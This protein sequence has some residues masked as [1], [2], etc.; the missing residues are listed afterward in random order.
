MEQKTK[1]LIIGAGP[2]GLM[3]AC[4]LKVQGVEPIII[5]ETDG[6]TKESR[7]VVVHARSIEIYD[8]LGIANE[9][10]LQGA[11]V[12]K[13]QLVIAN[14]KVQQLPFG[15]IGEGLSPFPFI[16]VL[17]QSKNEA[18][19]YEKLQKEGGSVSW[20]TQL[21]SIQEEEG[22]VRAVVRR[23]EDTFDIVADYVIAADGGKSPTRYALDVPFNGDTYEQIFFVADTKVESQ[24]GKDELTI[25]LSTE[26]FLA[27][28][29]MQGENRFR[30]IGILP[31]EY[32]NES[33]QSFEEIV[34][35]IQ[36]QLATPVNFSDTTW[37]SVYRLHHRC[38]EN[39]RKGRIFFAGD[40]AHVHSPAGGQGMNTGLQDAYNLAWKLAMV[41]NGHAGEKLLDT[42]NQERLPFAQSLIRST[43]KAFSMATSSHWY[44]KLFRL[45]ILPLILPFILRMKK[46]RLKVF[47]TVSQTG[48]KYINSD[49]TVNRTMDILTVKA[50]E[51][52][53]YLKTADGESLYDKL[54]EPFFYA[55]YFSVKEG[56]KL[57]AE[58]KV[59][60]NEL[61]HML[62]TIDL[63]EEK[64]LINVL[65]VKTDMVILLRPDLYIG[66]VTDE[67]AKVA[68]D[69][70]RKLGEHQKGTDVK[71]PITHV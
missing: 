64:E 35:L 18:L 42:Y 37:F 30:V 6:I 26:T 50:G 9:A 69:Y 32:Q 45:Q 28:F 47:K 53:P 43:D 40:A 51:R 17:E 60:E 44:H 56:S 4:Q 7:A 63:S 27:L 59:Q 8:H 38:I 14:K 34:P 52:F 16:L 1:V 65:K 46:Y 24:W 10:L 36:K 25:Y 33:P 2:T 66:L 41:V 20:G 15:N 12:Q 61:P 70:L 21:L 31:K 62:R 49:L 55:L 19:L 58:M 5:D 22:V 13:V 29:P 39:F 57:A 23:G 54:M 48:I 3:A 11:I 71:L 67:G 68:G